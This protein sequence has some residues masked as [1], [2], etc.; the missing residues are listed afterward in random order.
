VAAR[1]RAE[2][3]RWPA[4]GVIGVMGVVSLFVAYRLFSQKPGG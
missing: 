1:E 4:V 2:G 3:M